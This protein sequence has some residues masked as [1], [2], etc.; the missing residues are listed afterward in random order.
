M[1]KF[2]SII[3]CLII[4]TVLFTGCQK[5][6][7]ITGYDSN[8]KT[9]M[10]DSC[11]VAENDNFTL[12][13]DKEDLNVSF[14]CKNNETVWNTVPENDKAK[15]DEKS[16]LNIRV[17]DT[18]VRTESTHYSSAATRVS[19]EKSQNGVTI[20]YYFDEVQISVPVTY[21]LRDDSLLLSIDGKDVRQG[22]K[23]YQLIAA[24]PAPMISHVSL[25]VPALI[26]LLFQLNHIQMILNQLVLGAMV[27]KMT[28]QEF[29][30][31][32]KKHL[33]LLELML[34]QVTNSKDILLFFQHFS[35]RIM[36]ISMEYLLQMV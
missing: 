15:A 27:L 33:V 2:V 17:Q 5:K 3:L 7:W 21:T 31:L 35:L 4:M 18:Q 12:S 23:R 28:Q 34:Q 30:V 36:I 14:L 22:S 8:S 29:F 25:Q 19:A 9:T 26:L 1:K 6:S 11:V 16:T 32:Q 10:I 24:Q 20:T 13:F